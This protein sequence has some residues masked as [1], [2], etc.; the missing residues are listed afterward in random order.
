MLVLKAPRPYALPGELTAKGFE[1]CDCCCDWELPNPKRP[2]PVFDWLLSKDPNMLLIRL[3][4]SPSLNCTG[5]E[6][7]ERAGG[8]RVRTVR[9]VLATLLMDAGV[10]S[11]DI[12]DAATFILGFADVAIGV[13]ISSNE[14]LRYQDEGL[15]TMLGESGDVASEAERVEPRHRRAQ[16]RRSFLRRRSWLVHSLTGPL[17]YLVYWHCS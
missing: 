7:K 10:K 13:L 14:I 11:E 3:A 12:E 4:E 8:S 1:D 17:T 16:L 2:P 6:C 5:D 15:L 9:E